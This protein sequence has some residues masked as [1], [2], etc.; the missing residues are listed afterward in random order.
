MNMRPSCIAVAGVLLTLAACGGSD[1]DNDNGATAPVTRVESERCA[2]LA[3]SA[4]PE[5]ST[6]SSATYNAGN[7]TVGSTNVTVP[8]CRV[9]A[10]SKPTADSNIGFEVWMPPAGSWNGKFQG[11]GSGSSAGSIG[12]AAMLVALRDGYAVMA[13][14]NGHLTDTR[15]LAV[16][17]LVNL[18][19]PSRTRANRIIPCR[20]NGMRLNMQGAHFFVRDT[21]TQFITAAFK[22]CL[23][24]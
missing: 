17:K 21:F 15:G 6:I 9:V 16:N 1:D 24:P 19:G 14:D 2:V 8:F 11:V 18:L 13:T 5:S 4:L 10:A 20:A 7:V 23:Y 3:Q 22:D 12:T